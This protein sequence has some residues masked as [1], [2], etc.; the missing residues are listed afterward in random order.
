MANFATETIKGIPSAAKKVLGGIGSFLISPL[1]PF[2][3]DV[4]QLLVLKEYERKFDDGEIAPETWVAV[5]EES[6]LLKK[7]SSQIMG[8]VANSVLMATPIR[9][10]TTLSTL[11]K[12]APTIKMLIGQGIKTGAQ[13]GGAFGV[14]GQL[15]AEPE[16]ELGKVVGA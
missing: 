14:A 5:A 3:E 2:G 15:S 10:A 1:K 7:S 11:S 8:D 4:A 16:V 9:G 12:T 6:Q 13:I